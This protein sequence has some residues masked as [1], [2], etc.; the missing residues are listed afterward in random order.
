MSQGELTESGVWKHLKAY[1]Y[2]YVSGIQFLLF[3][4]FS[5]LAFVNRKK[6]NEDTTE[7]DDTTE[8]DDNKLS[9]NFAAMGVYSFFAGVGSFVYAGESDNKITNWWK[10]QLG[11]LFFLLIYFLVLHIISSRK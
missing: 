2:N 8:K 9:R 10:A 4:L 1:Y 5:I 3:I 6:E 7:D 11:C